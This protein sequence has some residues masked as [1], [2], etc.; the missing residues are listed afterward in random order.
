MDI[1]ELVGS[2]ELEEIRCIELHAEVRPDPAPQGG[3]QEEPNLEIQVNP[4][5]SHPGIET[6]F[7]AVYTSGS[8]RIVAAHAVVY[9][10]EGSP[11]E[12]LPDELHREFIEKVSVMTAFPYLRA[13][14]SQLANSLGVAA[15]P[16]PMLRQGMFRMGPSDEPDQETLPSE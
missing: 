10:R 4:V 6:W 11:S 15:P 12:G 3:E 8:Y 13:S 16:L 1:L 9:A 7:R 14:V 5:Q 2:T